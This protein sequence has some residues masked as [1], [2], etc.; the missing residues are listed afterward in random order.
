[1]ITK[2]K[3]YLEAHQKQYEL[4]RYLIAGGI[5]TLLS[6]FISYTG[7]FV[8]APKTPMTGSV[9]PW[10]IHTINQATASHVMISNAI[11]W[12]ISVLFAFWI[13]RKMVFQVSG[14]SAGQKWMELGQF[15]LGRVL[16]FLIFEEGMALL[17]KWMG[18][19]NMIN[20]II[21]L[22]FVMVFNYVVS[23]FWVFKAKPGEGTQ[24]SSGTA[25]A[26]K[27]T[28]RHKS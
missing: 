8:L 28:V 26:P 21:V 20:R 23:K 5:T 16:S 25:S 19:S 14:G 17:L 15:A 13:N 4:L 11:S 2:L 3:N 22:I 18:V 12:V 7:C 9:I 6:M 10:V 1:M 24:A 27:D